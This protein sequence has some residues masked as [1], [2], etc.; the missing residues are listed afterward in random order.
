MVHDGRRVQVAGRARH[1]GASGLWRLLL[2]LEAAHL[3]RLGLGL[4]GQQGG[5]HVQLGVRVRVVAQEPG[6]GALED[7]LVGEKVASFV[8]EL[9][10]DGRLALVLG[11][12]VLVP[13]LDL[14]VREL[15][16]GG[17]LDAVL[18]GEVLLGLEAGLELLELVVREGSARLALLPL[19][20]VVAEDVFDE[21]G[22]VVVAVAAGGG[23]VVVAVA[24]GRA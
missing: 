8:E 17:Q 16:L 9:E 10:A 5:C 3:D 15:Q 4:G 14:R 19:L 12:P 24:V 2:L 7:R 23:G 13:G 20:A 22:G 21:E 1:G 6:P 18:N 11:A